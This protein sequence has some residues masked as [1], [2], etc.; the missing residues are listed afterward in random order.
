MMYWGTLLGSVRHHGMIP[1][2]NEADMA[3][4]AAQRSRLSAALKTLRPRYELSGSHQRLKLYYA[5]GGKFFVL[6]KHNYTWPF[7]DIAFYE[8]DGTH[9]WNNDPGWKTLYN[10]SDVFLL[11]QRP[12][13]GSM[14][15]APRDS[16][17]ICRVQYGDISQCK[18]TYY[19]H[20]DEN[21]P[22]SRRQTS[23]CTDLLGRSYPFVVRRQTDDGTLEL[24]K[25]GSR[26]LSTF[27][28]E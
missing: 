17:A 22:K 7:L 24:L 14:F 5:T 23:R 9:I 28:D 20:K 21:W 1:W 6:D 2:D 13:D 10:K 26:V 4:L 8:E 3:V 16:Y 19:V 11:K 25:L 15:N 18:T 12:Y 27:T